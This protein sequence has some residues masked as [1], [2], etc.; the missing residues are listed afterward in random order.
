M[1]NLLGPKCV[2]LLGHE[3]E[4][5]SLLAERNHLHKEQL[6]QSIALSLSRSG[7]ARS[8]QALEAALQSFQVKNAPHRGNPTFL[9]HTDILN[10]MLDCRS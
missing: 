5:F 1:R 2:E 10:P 3:P 7:E 8:V 9:A 4:V 6:P